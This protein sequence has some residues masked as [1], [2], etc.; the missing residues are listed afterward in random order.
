MLTARLSALQDLQVDMKRGI[1]ASADSSPAAPG[2]PHLVAIQG[3]LRDARSRL[4]LLEK[5]FI[6]NPEYAL[7]VPLL[8]KD[9]ENLRAEL[10]RDHEETGKTIDRMYDQNKWFVGLMFSMAV[11]LIGLAIS[12]FFHAR[13]TN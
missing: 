8:R 4:D 7:S 9:F 3:S 10:V 13:K 5:A 6:P 11:G 12:N 1:E 2:A